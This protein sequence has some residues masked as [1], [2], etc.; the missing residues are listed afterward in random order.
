[1][2]LSTYYL[3]LFLFVQ[4]Y[5][6]HAVRMEIRLEF[7]AE[8]HRFFDLPRWGIDDEVLNDFIA[9]DIAITNHM[10][11]AVYDPEE[12]D[13]WPLPLDKTDLHPGV[14]KQD[15]SYLNFHY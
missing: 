14:L 10:K 15:S 7:A 3:G 9:R 12:D 2:C 1:M 4:W 8:G 6:F 5:S 11:G 13:F